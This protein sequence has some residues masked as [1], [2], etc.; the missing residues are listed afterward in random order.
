M[1]QS[2]EVIA[3]LEYYRD[4]RHLSWADHFVY[5]LDGKGGRVALPAKFRFLPPYKSQMVF[6]WSLAVM[7]NGEIAVAGVA[8]SM[9]D[10]KT[11]SRQTVVAF[12]SNRGATWSDY[13]PV[14]GCSS[15]PMMLA[16]LGNGVLSFVQDDTTPGGIHR[17]FSRDYGRTRPDRV[18]QP[19]VESNGGSLYMEGNPLVELGED[20][21]VIMAEAGWNKGAPGSKVKQ[22]QLGNAF[23][24]WSYDGGRT[25]ANESQPAE[26]RWTDTLDGKTYELG[27]SECALARAGNDWLVIALRTNSAMR[28]APLRHDNFSGTAVSVSSDEGKTWSPLNRVFAA[29]RMHANLIRL[30]NDTLVMTVIR[31]LDLGEDGRLASY[32]RGCDAVVSHDNGQ[33]WRTDRMY[34][35]DEF[36]AMGTAEQWYKCRCGHLYSIALEDGSILTTYGNYN[37][38]G[39]VILW[40]PQD[41]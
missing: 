19:P 7:D 37:N 13:V 31:R 39:A 1:P 40:R 34:V 22:G 23:I 28:F 3:G 36:S 2:N 9:D 20:G 35:L 11:C 5:R 32:R 10:W 12:S 17:F 41:E 6:P 33:T 38:G 16:Y 26:W 25:Y 18:P 8:C 27:V 15:R 14:E 29:G 24:R 21:K 4:H 30:S